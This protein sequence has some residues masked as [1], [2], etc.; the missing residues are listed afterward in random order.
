MQVVVKKRA[1]EQMKEL[2]GYVTCAEEYERRAT[3]ARQTL[4]NKPDLTSLNDIKKQL[5][6]AKRQVKLAQIT[7]R[8]QREYGSSKPG[9]RN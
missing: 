6:A 9:Q 5:K 1:E 2:E 4:E 3:L 8:T 7:V